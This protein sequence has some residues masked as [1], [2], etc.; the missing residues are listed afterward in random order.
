MEHYDEIE[1]L[2]EDD[3]YNEIGSIE[4][5]VSNGAETDPTVPEHVKNITE[6]EK[7]LWNKHPKDSNVHVT[8]TE[9]ETWNDKQPKGDY[10]LKKDIPTKTSQLINDSGYID[11]HQDI[12]ELTEHV[13][14]TNIHVTD[15]DKENW[16]NKVNSA[17]VY[18]KDETDKTFAKQSQLPDVSN[19]ITASVENLENYY[20]KTET[21]TQEEIN[22]KISKI[23]TSSFEVVEQLPSTDIKDNVIYLVL[24]EQ[25]EEQNKYTEY[26][27]VNGEWEK[28][29]TLQSTI[30]IEELQKEIEKKAN[31]TDVYSK[32]DANNMFLK[33]ADAEIKYA[34]K[35]EIPD[36]SNLVTND[37]LEKKN[38]ASK[39]DI[40][41]DYVNNETFKGH[42]TDD[43]KHVSTEEKEKWN[44]I[45]TIET[46][47]SNI[48]TMIGNINT[49]L[50]TL[51]EVSE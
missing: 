18:S 43:T 7:E 2:I 25:T 14:D 42:T 4:E 12:S 48:K 27:Y 20:K 33:S 30:N 29:G 31:I 39:D 50:A 10:A 24:T 46:E 13:K 17:D 22:D 34:E 16:N 32:E 8:T 3:T 15:K 19:F 23:K 36:T 11:K 41:T 37:E 1:S 28:L 21:Y 9:K 6:A 26:V 47:V 40:P 45:D 38:Y 35:T 51:T 44:K 49:E 5:N